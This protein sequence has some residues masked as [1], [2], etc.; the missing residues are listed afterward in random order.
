VVVVVGKTPDEIRVS[1][2]QYIRLLS[3]LD[4]ATRGTCPHEAELAYEILDDAR[5]WLLRND[6]PSQV[7]GQ[8]E[9]PL[10]WDARAGR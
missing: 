6:T 3:R 2:D 10:E 5:R 4:Q 1:R 7:D 9:L 8:L